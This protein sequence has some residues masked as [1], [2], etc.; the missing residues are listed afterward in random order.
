M[1]LNRLDTL[2]LR[3]AF[4]EDLF[5]NASDRHLSARASCAV[6]LESDLDDVVVSVLHEFDVPAVSLQERSDLVQRVIDF[7]FHNYVPPLWFCL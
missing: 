7:L 3:I 1:L 2:D 6:T 5:D 4:L